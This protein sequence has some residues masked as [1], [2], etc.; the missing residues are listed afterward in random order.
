[1]ICAGFVTSPVRGLLRST[2]TLFA[3]IL[4][5]LALPEWVA[6]LLLVGPKRIASIASC[7]A[8]YGLVSEVK[9]LSARAPCGSRV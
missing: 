8:D 2:Y 4:F 3:P 5:R 1:M 7:R 9:V 6:R